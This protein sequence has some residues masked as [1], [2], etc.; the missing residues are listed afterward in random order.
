VLLGRRDEC[1]QIERLLDEAR[2]GRSGVLVIRGEPGIGKTA[3]LEHARERAAG[4]TVV[5]AAGVESEVEL[6]FAGLLDICRPLREH[7]DEVP[8]AHA[9]AL[10]A[11]LGL[12]ESQARDRFAI[13]AGTLALLAAAAEARPLLALVDDAQWLDRSSQDALRF[14]ARRLVADRACLLFAARVS[15]A[16]EFDASSLPTLELGGVALAASEGLLSAHGSNPVSPEVAARLHAAT[17]GSPL[18]LLELS[19][20]L[21]LEQLAGQAPLPEPLPAG[22]SLER[23]FARRAAGLAEE[24]NRGLV[25]A[26]AAVTSRTEVIEKALQALGLDLDSLEPAEDAGLIQLADGRVDFRHTL[27]RSAVYHAAPPSARRAAHRALAQVLADG[28]H[29]DERAWHLAAGVLGPDEEAARG[30]EQAAERAIKRGGYAGAGDALERAAR[31]TVDEEPHLRRLHGAA[32]ASWEAGHTEHA[33]ALLEEGIERAGELPV[34]SQMLHLRGHIEH[35][36]GRVLEAHSMLE[37]AAGLLEASDPARAVAILADAAEAALYAGRPSL[38]LA[39]AR[40]ARELA[41]RDAGVAD[42]LADLVLAEALFFSGDADSASALLDR[43]SAGLEGNDLLRD[44][45]RY[46][47]RLAIELGVGERTREARRTFER[48]I[49]LAHARGSV[50]ALPYALEAAAWNDTHSGRWREAYAAASQAKAVALETGQT[51]LVAHCDCDLAWIEAARGEEEPCRESVAEALALA[52]G[53][54]LD[55]I[56][57]WASSAL[58]LLDLGLGRL[59]AAVPRLQEVALELESHAMH[60]R[61]SMPWPELVE[62]HLRTGQLAEAERALAAFLAHGPPAGVWGSAV[63]ARCRGHLAGEDE[64]EPHFLL[65]LELHSTADDPFAHARTLLCFGERLRRSGHKTKAR[66]HLREALAVFD[67]LQAKPWAE[68]VRV[69]LR[70]TGER[71]RSRPQL[72]EELTPQEIQVGLQVAEG[73]TNKEA[74]AALFLSPKTIEYHLASVYRKLDVRS[75]RELIKR[76]SGGGL[77][78][79]EPA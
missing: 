14:A 8:L 61:D 60:D 62:A 37:S 19:S 49:E 66:R 45:P 64:F 74:A 6:E 15:E 52:A 11:A 65:A 26:A 32:A 59:G 35:L 51:S 75:R 47:A 27:I 31:L 42:L 56:R 70:A 24:T 4:L 58:A 34:R 69:E 12:A 46:L 50:S 48:A 43:A 44:D 53:R 18:A 5:Q 72:G 36:G 16:R 17:H 10:R 71:I 7:L 21:T 78:A 63:V 3:L 25:L 20:L 55:M 76:F 13:G 79:L 68:K 41:P 30:L 1:A 29:V 28:P 57:W 73:K 67:E 9:E 39:T 54:Q 33:I 23:A 22:P 77:A 38:G 40:R 2:H